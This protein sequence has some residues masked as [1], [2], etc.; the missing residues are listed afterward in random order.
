MKTATKSLMHRPYQEPDDPDPKLDIRNPM[1]PPLTLYPT[2]LSGQLASF[3][4]TFL[5]IPKHP[6]PSHV[7]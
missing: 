4:S 5:V 3:G 2:D 6:P 1:E 7:E